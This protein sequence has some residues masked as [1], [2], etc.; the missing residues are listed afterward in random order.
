MQY[1]SEQGLL[2]TRVSRCK[3]KDIVLTLKTKDT[4]PIPPSNFYK[5]PIPFETVD[6]KWDGPKVAEN[7]IYKF[8]SASASCKIDPPTKS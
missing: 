1:M 7:L 5:L 4:T 8:Y 2:L 6:K 3:C